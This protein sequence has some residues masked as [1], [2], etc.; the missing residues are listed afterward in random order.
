M[1]GLSR[2][3]R[4]VS[5]K[6]TKE[7]SPILEKRVSSYYL[8]VPDPSGVPFVADVRVKV[9]EQWKQIQPD[10]TEMSVYKWNEFGS[11]WEVLPTEVNLSKGTLE[12][13]IELQEPTWIAV[14]VL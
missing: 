12:V 9:L 7:F 1:Q 5:I 6:P 4:S 2:S 3:V 13:R 8:L 10:L 11:K 14:G